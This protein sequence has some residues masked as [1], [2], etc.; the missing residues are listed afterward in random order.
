MYVYTFIYEHIYMYSYVNTKYLSNQILL[1]K[2][3]AASE[4][5]K[6]YAL[7][8][9]F[10]ALMNRPKSSNIPFVHV[11]SSRS[12]EGLF[13]LCVFLYMYI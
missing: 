5:E 3:D 12:G 9:V 10:E 1:T 13:D 2:A 6:K 7:K 4:S 11:L 8:S